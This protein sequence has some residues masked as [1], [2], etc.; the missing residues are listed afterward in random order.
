MIDKISFTFG[1]LCICGSEWLALRQ[2]DCFPLYYYIIM[3][4]LLLWRFIT[5]SRDKYQLFMLGK[6]RLYMI[7]IQYYTVDFCYFVNFSVVLQTAFF[8]ANIPWFKV[9]NQTNK[10][11]FQNLL[12][13]LGKLHSLHGSTHVCHYS[14]EEQ[15]GM[16]MYSHLFNHIQM[17]GVSQP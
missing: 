6:I 15:P 13:E 10:G 9:K 3:S 7:N 5:Y 16:N 1:V 2:P 12:Y 8:P 4:T 11:N 14:L 17:L